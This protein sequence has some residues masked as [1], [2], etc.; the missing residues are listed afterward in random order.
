MPL[1]Q[2]CSSGWILYHAAWCVPH[3]C[4]AISCT[5]TCWDA[6]CATTTPRSSCA[7]SVSQFTP[8]PA[9]DNNRGRGAGAMMMPRVHAKRSYRRKDMRNKQDTHAVCAG[10]TRRQIPYRGST[11]S[12]DRCGL[13]ISASVT[14]LALRRLDNVPMPGRWKV[15][16]YDPRRD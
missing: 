2:G 14:P 11:I 8:T 1:H 15:S 13:F 3:V 6:Q 4:R 5:S 16:N 10:K 9:F 7:Q 12:T